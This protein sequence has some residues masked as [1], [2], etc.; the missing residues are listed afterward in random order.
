MGAA[1]DL[2][3]VAKGEVDPREFFESLTHA[4][5][6]G[7]HAVNVHI[8]HDAPWR[9]PL[10]HLCARIRIHVS[11]VAS[12]PMMWAQA[13]GAGD[14]SYVAVL[15]IRCPPRAEWWLQ[16][17]QAMEN[18]LAAFYGPVE[19]G[20]GRDDG[21]ITGYLAEYAQFAPPLQ[22]WLNEVP[23]NNA[24]FQRDLLPEPEQLRRDGF[25]KTFLVWRLAREL[26]LRFEPIEGLTVTYRKG[27]RIGPYVVRRYRHG[28]C[29]AGAR[30]RHPGQPPLWLCLMATP[31]L[32][33][34]R[35]AR[36]ARACWRRADLRSALLRHLGPVIASEVA[37]SVGEFAGYAFGPGDSCEHLD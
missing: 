9:G 29:F 1:I 19:P 24:V 25:S 35:I 22:A 11:G 4:A 30:H 37:W 8:A 33:A 17:R 27:F 13:I 12:L 15:D 31:A 7:F 32:P 26:G 14:S 16:A 20:W 3:V 34:M 5:P 36:I 23:G 28:R 6:A 21:R 2:A 10:S 18:G